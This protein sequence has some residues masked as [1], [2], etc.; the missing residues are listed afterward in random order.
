MP[1]LFLR[2]LY[3]LA[4]KGLPELTTLLLLDISIACEDI[5]GWLKKATFMPLRNKHFPCRTL[6]LL[7]QDGIANGGQVG[8]MTEGS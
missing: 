5:M 6:V 2:L 4:L 8:L 7:D 1:S 3:V